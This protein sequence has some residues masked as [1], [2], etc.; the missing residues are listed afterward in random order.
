MTEETVTKTPDSEF[1]AANL[2]ILRQMAESIRIAHEINPNSWSVYRARSDVVF[3]IASYFLLTSPNYVSKKFAIMINTE[4]LD[5]I[6][7]QE[8]KIYIDPE[9]PKSIPGERYLLPQSMAREM[10][11]KLRDAHEV[12]VRWAAESVRTH[13]DRWM[14]Y[15]PAIVDKIEQVTGERVP[16]PG[17]LEDASSPVN[18]VQS[19][20]LDILRQMAESIR[21]A[22]EINPNSWAVLNRRGA[23]SLIVS[24][25]IALTTVYPQ[26][27]KA[28]ILVATDAIDEEV[29]R[30][31]SFYRE[32][33]AMKTIRCTFFE[34]P[35]D[36]IDNALPQLRHAHLDGVR[37]AAREVRTRSAR[38]SE[39]L[40]DMLRA[41]ER[42]IGESLPRPGYL[43]DDSLIP[44]AGPEP[45]RPVLELVQESFANEG[46]LYSK[47]QL[48]TFYTALQTKGF[49]VL[50]GISGTGKS[51]IAQ[52]FAGMLPSPKATAQLTDRDDLIRV[53][54]HP[55]SKKS[56]YLVL[57]K[58]QVEKFP[59]P[60]EGGTD[61]V[62]LRFGEVTSVGLLSNHSFNNGEFKSVR[63]Y[64]TDDVKKRFQGLGLDQVVYFEPLVSSEGSITAFHIMPP[65]EVKSTATSALATTIRNHLFLSVRPDWR[66]S[67]ALI[68]YYNPLLNQYEWTDF[69][70]FILR[71]SE[72]FRAGEPTA[73]FVILDEMNLAHVE[74]YFADLLSILESG[75][76]ENGWT[77]EAIRITVPE[78]EDDEDSPPSEIRLPP[79]LYIIGTVN[80]DETTHAFSPKVLDRAFTMELSDVDFSHYPLISEGD[81]SE[82]TAA[83]SSQI[84]EAFTRDG[85]FARIDKA[86]IHEVV[87]THP[88]IRIWLQ[89]LNELLAM[90]RMN[91]GYRVFDEIA[92]FLANADAN[93][94][95]ASFGGFESAF[96]TAVLMKVLPKFSGS[97]ARLERPLLDL[98]AWCVD[99]VRL[100]Q[101][102][103]RAAQDGLGDRDWLGSS[104]AE[105]NALHFPITGKR[106]MRM[107]DALATEGFASFG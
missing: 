100:P 85:R 1:E 41:I 24:K 35:A 66:D 93:D 97:A 98:L 57:P 9:T 32:P 105:P 31:F 76:D 51:K 106:V 28:T 22:H 72:S 81:G 94:G 50:S 102:E 37:L 40:P 4:H 20:D 47:E 33:N 26:T 73:W 55:Y 77:R 62:D 89:S 84:L 10:L 5:S 39:H 38:A 86:E 91:F 52:H 95:F 64:L 7:V 60:V 17:Y 71:A 8:L 16:R 78:L 11:P 107:L 83:E 67:R 23:I 59:L 36:Q 92:Q 2:L 80:M 43:D 53:K 12:V 46:L 25:Y 44:F 54:V 99:P 13:S 56:G 49:V 75:R 15:V 65:D 74:Y 27:S 101:Q 87:S 79:N 90:S 96:D 42:A 34:V 63:L 68:G 14:E 19:F 103:I 21:I 61:S 58:R 69:L 45:T 104:F 88:N 82:L 18:L 30:E 6:L 3:H 48:A 29:E 70:R